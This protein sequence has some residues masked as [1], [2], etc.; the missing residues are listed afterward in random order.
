MFDVNGDGDLDK[1]EFQ[2]VMEMIGTPRVE[3]AEQ[4]EGMRE[5]AD[6]DNDGKISQEE[7]ITFWHPNPNPNP[8]PNSNGRNSSLSGRVRSSTVERMRRVSL[9]CTPR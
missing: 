9:K 7:F 1:D 4:W 3:I 6:L 5:Q 2:G 8:N